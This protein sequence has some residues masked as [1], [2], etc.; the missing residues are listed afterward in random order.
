MSNRISKHLC[1]A[2]VPAGNYRF[3]QVVLMPMKPKKNLQHSTSNL[4]D[5]KRLM[6]PQSLGVERWLLNV[7]CLDSVFGSPDSESR[8]TLPKRHE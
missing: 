2:S 8:F 6:F 1:L 7:E 4:Q 3:V 5:P